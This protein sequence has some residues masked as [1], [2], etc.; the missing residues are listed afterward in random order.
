MIRAACT[1]L[2]TLFHG[3]PGAGKT[4]LARRL[5]AAGAGVRLSTDDWQDALGANLTD[6]SFHEALQGV[7]HRHALDLLTHGVGVI[8][9]DGLWM[10]AERTTVF[11]AARDRGARIHWHVFDVEPEELARRLARRA[12]E[13]RRGAVPIPPEELKRILGLIEPPTDAE[14]TGVDQV[15]THR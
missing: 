11:N 15:T 9:E 6:E 14:L 1:P 8:L 13:R 12:S 4:T 7:L 10:R 5:E 2:L 3:P